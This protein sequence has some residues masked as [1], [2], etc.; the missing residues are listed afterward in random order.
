MSASAIT[1]PSWTPWDTK[2]AKGAALGEMSLPDPK[3]KAEDARETEQ[4]AQTPEA[5]PE[6]KAGQINESLSS[7]LFAA[8]LDQQDFAQTNPMGD[9][10]GQDDI[11]NG[12]TSVNGGSANLS[13]TDTATGG[14]SGANAEQAEQTEDKRGVSAQQAGAAVVIGNTAQS[15]QAANSSAAQ[16]T[17]ASAEDESALSP[18]LL[19]QIE[20]A[21]NPQ[22]ASERLARY[23]AYA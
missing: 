6:E 4:A 12:A 5:S 21:R 20:A 15:T 11:A 17:P 8:L 13:E 9:E 16:T 7:Q 14:A 19:A 22:S 18:M 2:H 3:L 1:G 10:S 23:Q